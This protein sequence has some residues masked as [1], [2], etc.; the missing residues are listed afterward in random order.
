M[1]FTKRRPST[2]ELLTLRE[3]AYLHACSLDFFISLR[4]LTPK[5]VIRTSYGILYAHGGGTGG[6][7]GAN[8]GTGNSDLGR[9]R[10]ISS[11][12]GYSTTVVTKR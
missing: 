8:G 11:L 9:T 3:C 10:T 5:T 12:D 1:L 2:D 7:G 4:S 6:R